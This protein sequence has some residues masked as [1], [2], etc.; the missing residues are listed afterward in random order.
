MKILKSLCFSALALSLIVSS[1]VF[2]KE[3]SIRSPMGEDF[4]IDVQPEDTFFNVID[5][6][7]LSF[8]TMEAEQSECV[9]TMSWEP[10]EYVLQFLSN[11]KGQKSV[12]MERNYYSPLIE[13]ERKDIAFIVNTLGN[14][15]LVKIT[16]E[17]AALKKAGDRIDHIHPFCFLR[18]IFSDDQMKVSIYNMQG[19]GW[20]W[21][22]FMSGLKG[23]LSDE[24]AKGNLRVEFIQQFSEQLKVDAPTIHNIIAEN[25]WDDLVNYLIF[26]IPR[27]TG[28]D[29]YDM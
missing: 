1:N 5:Q 15:S 7:E 21:K 29:R 9:S 13:K 6:L 8:D 2:A 27:A 16:K 23:S 12:G 22:D 24:A 25:R 26:N 18:C 19:R 10:R 20:I 11:T 4:V 28:S 17:R 3:I 14:A